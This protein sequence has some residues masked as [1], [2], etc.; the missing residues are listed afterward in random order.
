MSTRSNPQSEAHADEGEAVREEI[1][2]H[3]RDQTDKAPSAAERRP[4]NPNASPADDIKLLGG[5]GGF[6][7]AVK[8]SA[9]LEADR[10]NK[11]RR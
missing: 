3:L 6:S 9:E 8:F 1:R 2:Q 5:L 11:R 10:K 7:S 4:D